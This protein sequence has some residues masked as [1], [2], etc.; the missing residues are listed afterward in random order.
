ML[1]LVSVLV[2]RWC[3]NIKGC[4]SSIHLTTTMRCYSEATIS[5]RSR[6]FYRIITLVIPSKTKAKSI[7]YWTK[8]WRMRHRTQSNTTSTTMKGRGKSKKRW[9][10]NRR[11]REKQNKQKRQRRTN[12]NQVGLVSEGRHPRPENGS[13][14]SSSEYWDALNCERFDL[15]NRDNWIYN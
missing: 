2:T 6:C 3:W 11:R 4:L 1:I 15:V 5:S 7:K 9:K 14:V 13:R 10:Q 12:R 8:F